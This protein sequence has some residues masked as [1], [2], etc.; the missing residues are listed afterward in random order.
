MKYALFLGCTI[1]VRA[2]NYELATR[3][4]ASALGIE[5]IDLDFT[6]CGYPI[7]SLDQKTSLLMA[8]RNLAL[9]EKNGRLNIAT[10][11]NACTMILTKANKLLIHDEKVLKEINESLKA[12]GLEYS[13]KIF[14][15]H[16][17]RILFEDFGIDKIKKRIK[18]PLNNLKIIA[19]YGCHYLRPSRIYD[20]F[21][22]S[23]NPY[24]LD[25]LI[26]VTGAKSIKYSKRNEC[27]G[28]PLLIVDESGAL[29]IANEKL[30]QMKKTNADA[31]VVICPFCGLMY[32]AFQA[33]IEEKIG[34][35]YN[36]PV[37]Y[38]PQLLG[39]AL[40]IDPKKLGVDLNRVKLT[41]L[42]SKIGLMEDVK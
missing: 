39:L 34:K 33:E 5:L 12:L 9:A 31:I 32:D 29:A 10:L 18:H 14:I 28:G 21:D 38:Y 25:M 30:E 7:E 15:K 20:N 19:F 24:T 37:L 22:N 35:K 1:P 17:V 36:F 8:T 4:V 2:Q 23:E 13:G 6:C 27:C 26:E 16:F 40:G 3:T 42:M 41:Y 11:C